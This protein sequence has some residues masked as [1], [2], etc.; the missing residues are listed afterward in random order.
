MCRPIFMKGRYNP[1]VHDEWQ[2][3]TVLVGQGL[4]EWPNPPIYTLIGRSKCSVS[5][6]QVAH[7]QKWKVFQIGQ[8]YQISWFLSDK[9]YDMHLQRL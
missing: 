2:R 4:R 8:T 6:D 5:L 3:Y 9:I 7:H 1:I